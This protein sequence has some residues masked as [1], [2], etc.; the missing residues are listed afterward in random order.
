MKNLTHLHVKKLNFIH[1]LF[2]I[3]YYYL[4][5]LLFIFNGKKI[6]KMLIFLYF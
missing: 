6:R 3:K 2:L 5:L 4:K 1:Y